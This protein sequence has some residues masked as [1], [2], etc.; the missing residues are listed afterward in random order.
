[1]VFRMAED[2][3]QLETPGR[4]H[5]AVRRARRQ[6]LINRGCLRVR[7][8]GT[9]PRHLDKIPPK[10]TETGRPAI[11]QCPDVATPPTTT[12]PRRD[13]TIGGGPL[14]RRGGSSSG[15]AARRRTLGCPTPLTN[16]FH[17]QSVGAH[18][19][20]S[21]HHDTRAGFGCPLTARA[22]LAALA[23]AVS[24]QLPRCGSG[25]FGFRGR[26]ATAG[27]V[28]GQPAVAAPPLS[29]ELGAAQERAVTVQR[30]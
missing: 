27:S 11:L 5:L 25:F 8:D 23:S 29:G 17:R 20:A 18:T 3:R 30:W 19:R 6:R 28:S 12:P 4:S 9:D 26:I 22:M 7:A 13:P 15:Q 2:R 21:R 10:P 1:M 16:P 24:V 14:R